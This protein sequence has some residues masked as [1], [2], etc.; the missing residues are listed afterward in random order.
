MGRRLETP[1]LGGI[2][3]EHFWFHLVGQLRITVHLHQLVR[4]LKAPEGIDLSLRIAQHVC[5][6][7]RPARDRGRKGRAE[8]CVQILA[9]RLKAFEGRQFLVIGPCRVERNPIHIEKI[10]GHGIE[11]LGMSIAGHELPKGNAL[12]TADIFNAELTA[13]FPEGIGELFVVESPAAFGGGVEG[14]EFEAGNLVLF[15]EHVQAFEGFR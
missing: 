15:H 14:V 9:L 12:V 11:I 6:L 3:T 1:E 13:F 7:Q 4:N 10:V 8:F 5:A 2:L